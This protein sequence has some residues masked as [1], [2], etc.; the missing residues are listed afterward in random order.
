ML[1]IKAKTVDF[2]LNN[3]KKKNI[4]YAV[5][6]NFEKLPDIGRDLDILVDNNIK[7]IQKIILKSAKKFNWSHL[8]FD[9]SKSRYFINNNKVSMFYLINS[10]NLEFLQIDLF[11]SLSI[12]STPYY[13]IN[14]T[15]LETFRK[16][17]F[18]IPRNV[19][20][21]Y[22]IF[23]INNLLNNKSGNLKKILRYRK[24][25]LKL[26]FT[27]I[28]RKNIF[29]EDKLLKKIYELIKNKSFRSF[30][31]YIFIYKFLILINYFFK[32]PLRFYYL[33]NRSFEY[34]LLYFFQPS[35][36][37]LDIFFKKKDKKKVI[38]NFNNLKHKKFISKWS[39]NINKNF[40]DK[41]IFL[42]QRNILINQI[43]ENQSNKK[44]DYTKTFLKKLIKKNILIFGK[45]LSEK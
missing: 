16:K 43:T 32:N 22:N 8:I 20:Y 23:Q 18:I 3:L 26:N 2:I 24:N 39:F 17:Y 28:F 35:G 36:F 41:I 19:S 7:E 30:R 4:N 42:Q 21:T 44:N 31:K 27:S 5:L 1:N 14:N 34:T 40:F 15:C 13:K 25:F 9:Q 45:S 29:F 12:F 11:R 38:K 10:K 33:F 37:E 6:R